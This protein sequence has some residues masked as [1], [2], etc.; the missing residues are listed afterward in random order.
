MHATGYENQRRWSLFL[1]EA[2]K[3]L[4]IDLDIR[5]ATWPDTVA[6][7]QSPDTMLNFMCLFQTA[8]MRTP[9]ISLSRPI[10]PRAM[11]SGRTRSTRMRRSTSWIEAARVETDETKRAKLYKAFQELVADDAPSIFSVCSKNASWASGPM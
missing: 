9:T 1:L 8:T 5:P 6:V 7:A 3:S 4:N 10:I 2:L 11:A